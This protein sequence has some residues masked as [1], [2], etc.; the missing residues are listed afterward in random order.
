MANDEN[1][2]TDLAMTYERKYWLVWN[3]VLAKQYGVIDRVMYASDYVAYSYDLYSANPADDFKRWINFIRT[4]LNEVCA[5]CGWPTF[6]QDEIDG[7]LWK[8]AARLYG[9]T[10]DELI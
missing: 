5:Q 7:F 2:W 6:T 9:I 3:L 10:I 1:L 8:N 4:G